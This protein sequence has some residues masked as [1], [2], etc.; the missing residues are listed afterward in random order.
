MPR[1]RARLRQVDRPVFG[2]PVVGKDD[3]LLGKTLSERIVGSAND[4]S[5]VES[6]RDLVASAVVRMRVIP[7]RACGPWPES[8]R[9]CPL[10]TR[11]DRME[12]AA[13][14]VEGKM[15]SVPVNR[16]CNGET[17]LEIHDDAVA[18]V[19]L[20]SRTGNRSIVGE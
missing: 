3:E 15:Q 14:R 2:K 12:R 9:V 8:E 4:Y 1:M 19:Y 13:V 18:F 5:A 16:R 17:I 10:R 20:E 11:L 7:V 6:L